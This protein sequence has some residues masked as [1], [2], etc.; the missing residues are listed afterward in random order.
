MLASKYDLNS[1]DGGFIQNDRALLYYDFESPDVNLALVC[2]G[3][4]SYQE[5]I[6][7][8]LRS[9]DGMIAVKK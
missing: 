5:G 7:N 9:I 8:D 3:V 2:G 6:V 1:V 4:G